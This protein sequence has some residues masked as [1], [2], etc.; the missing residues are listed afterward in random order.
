M[1]P[2]SLISVDKRTEEVRDLTWTALLLLALVLSPTTVAV[3]ITLN[4]QFAK[5]VDTI[6]SPVSAKPSVLLDPV[7]SD[8]PGAVR[9]VAFKMDIA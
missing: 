5:P 4:A 6:A 8:G 7:N 1:L 3:G 9:S 2:K